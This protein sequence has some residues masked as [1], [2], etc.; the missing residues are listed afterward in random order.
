LYFEKFVFNKTNKALILPKCY[1]F[2]QSFGIK[3]QMS[4]NVNHIINQLKM[5]EIDINIFE[6]VLCQKKDL[7][8]EKKL[9]ILLQNVNSTVSF[10]VTVF[11]SKKIQLNSKE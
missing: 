5:T 6:Y 7:Y 8:N 10:V 1:N 9:G 2:V 11:P 4:K 3:K